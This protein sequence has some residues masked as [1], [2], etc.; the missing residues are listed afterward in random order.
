[1]NNNNIIKRGRPKLFT[2]EEQRKK[3]TR[4]MLNK[5]WYCVTCINNLNY[6]LA[7]KWNHMKTKK[8]I[9]NSNAQ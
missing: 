3:K 5:K 1:M 7:G 2:E 9:K 4:L 8:H 6:T